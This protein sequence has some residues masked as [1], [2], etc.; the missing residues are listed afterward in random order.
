MLSFF[1]LLTFVM[2]KHTLLQLL[3]FNISFFKS[4]KAALGDV[5]IDWYRKITHLGLVLLIAND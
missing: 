2:L 5:G 4:N 3:S 1:L